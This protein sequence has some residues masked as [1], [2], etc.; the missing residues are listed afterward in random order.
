MNYPPGAHELTTGGWKLGQSFRHKEQQEREV[1]MGLTCSVDPGSSL[2]TRSFSTARQ[3][4]SWCSVIL[5]R[6]K[7]KSCFPQCCQLLQSAAFSSDG[8]SASSLHPQTSLDN[9]CGDFFRSHLIYPH[10][11]LFMQ[12]LF[13]SPPSST[14]SPFPQ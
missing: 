4:K 3:G 13:Y 8:F 14:C 10:S 5:Q 12:Q 7:L 11:F 6:F 2:D 9:V 1:T